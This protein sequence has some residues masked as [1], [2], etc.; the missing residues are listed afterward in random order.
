MSRDG[1]YLQLF[2][3]HGLIRGHD[4]EMGRDADTGGQCKY[5][6]ELARALGR[7]EGV[8]TVELFTRLVRD[9]TVSSDYSVPVEPLEDNV[10]MVRI[11]CGGTKYIRKERLWPHLDEYVD[12][13]LKYTKSLGRIPDVVHG[14]Y[15]DAGYVASNLAGFLG[16]P[17]VFTGHSL[18]RPKKRK[19]LDEGRSEEDVVRQYAI[20]YRI[21]MEELAIERSDFIVTST[22]QEIE[23][24]YGMYR[25]RELGSYRVIPPGLELQQFFPYYDEELRALEEEQKQARHD[26]IRELN[27]FFRNPEKPFILALCRPDVRKNISGLIHA[28]GSDREL[29]AIA[30]LAIFAG[31]RADISQMGENEQEVLTEMLLLMDRY[32]LYGKMAIPKQHN[33]TQEV[34]ALYR[35]CGSKRGVFTN[36]AFTEPFGL[37][38]LEAGACGL[39]LVA[40][41]DGG[42]RDIIANCQNGLL[43]DVSDPGALAGALKRMLVEDELWNSCSKNGILNVR[44]HYSW[45]AHC[46]RYLEAIRSAAEQQP[47]STIAV[48]GEPPVGKRL[49]GLQRFL[50]TSIDPTLLENAEALEPLIEV[51]RREKGHLGFIVATGRSLESALETIESLGL[52]QPD[53]LISGIGTE[54]HYYGR[55]WR[56]RGWDTHI[57]ADWKPVETRGVLD[58]IPF[59]KRQPEEVQTQFK[60]SYLMEPSP[61]R[62]AQVHQ[63][64]SRRRLRYTLV[65]SHQR[66]LDCVPH[67]AGK[68]KA[69]RYVSYK[70]SIPLEQILVC[71]GSG[72]DEGML[73]G[74]PL[75]VVVA[76]HSLE[77]DS[78]QGKRTI[79]FAAGA[80]AAGILEG[81]EHYGFLSSGSPLAGKA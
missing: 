81:M 70:W 58:G 80:S 27:R 8:G 76:N 5:V 73:R 32:D 14:H 6:L 54:I 10:R 56:D 1:L 31:I 66:Y 55:S 59:V 7:Q 64:L 72:Q 29:Q 39:P 22:H 78:L 4:L 49:L 43:V 23:E 71:G 21:E 38:L 68:G 33:P 13:T 9:K 17:L 25:N 62:V 20:D 47:R 34:P 28:Y 44:K 48:P 24:Q 11:Q 15:A 50:C 40:T 61:D 18:G 30:N 63:E 65:Y 2:S 74:E 57:A 52:P 75:G 79:Y 37:T 16:A 60:L 67:R 45:E 36:P 26:M 51:L 12:K 3:I 46:Q 42:P 19:L 77:L 53:I 69:L 41:A 35:L